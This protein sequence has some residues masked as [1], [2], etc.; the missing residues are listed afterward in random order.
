MMALKPEEWKVFG[1]TVELERS[2]MQVDRVDMEIMVHDTTNR[3]DQNVE[4]PLYFTDLQFQP[5]SQKTGWIP[6]TQEFMDRIEFDVNEMRKY[7]S[8]YTWK[9]VTPTTYTSDQLGHKRMFNIMG[10]GHEVITI[11]NDL[12]EEKFW[13]LTDI[14]SQGLD[15]PV[16]ILTTGIDFQIIPKDNFE[17]CRIATN[18]GSI[19]PDDDQLYPGEDHPLNY[20]YTREFFF[21]GGQA[22]DILEVNATSMTARMNGSEVNRN[23]NQITVGSDVINIYKN[24]FHLIPRGSVRF[25]IEFYGRDANGKLADI[26]IG[27]GG[28][29]K[30][31]QWTYGVERL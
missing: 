25:R 4:I 23:I 3:D 21:N 6:N 17:L 5:G 30:F 11:P 14:A 27:Y 9:S 22:G 26:G 12:P 10:R 29:A 24:K 18:V 31:L 16:E 28:Q 1:G 8:S 15:R 13:R 7:D 2:H 19:L 20:R